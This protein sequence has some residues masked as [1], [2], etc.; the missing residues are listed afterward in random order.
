MDN[1]RFTPEGNQAIAIVEQ[2]AVDI[3]AAWETLRK[4]VSGGMAF[5]AAT[6]L[7]MQ[8]VRDLFRAAFTEIWQIGRGDDFEG[9]QE[10]SNAEAAVDEAAAEMETV[11]QKIDNEADLLGTVEERVSLLGRRLFRVV[12]F[13]GAAWTL[14]NTAK[15]HGAA[16]GDL[17]TWTGPVDKNTCDVCRE[18]MALGARPLGEI[19]RYPGRDSIC[20]DNCRHELAQVN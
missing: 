10:F 9:E 20:L 19:S 17:W 8:V 5:G 2:L 16:A 3:A 6:I 18:E 13:A 7:F 11:L 14:F 1:T 4:N 15:V 12:F